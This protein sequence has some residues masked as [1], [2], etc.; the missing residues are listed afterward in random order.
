[1]LTHLH[2]F[3]HIFDKNMKTGFPNISRKP[4]ILVYLLTIS[5]DKL[6]SLYQ[7]FYQEA[8]QASQDQLSKLAN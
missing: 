5:Q 3:V 7:T 6:L 1:M 4:V 2:R 8:E